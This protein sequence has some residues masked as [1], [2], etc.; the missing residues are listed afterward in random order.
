MQSAGDFL[1]NL[2]DTED[3]IDFSLKKSVQYHV[4]KELRGIRAYLSDDVEVDDTVGSLSRR[5]DNLT[6]F[7]VMS[8]E[9]YAP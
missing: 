5:G 8:Y 2:Q 1:R 3:A 7:A 4:R 6:K 9:V